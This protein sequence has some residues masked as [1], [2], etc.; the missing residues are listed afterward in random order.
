MQRPYCS[1]CKIAWS[2]Y[3]I[4]RI[5]QCSTCHSNLALASFYPMSKIIGG[6]AI[7]IISLLTIVIMQIPIIWIGGFIVGITIMVNGIKEKKSLMRLDKKA[8]PK[9]ETPPPKVNNKYLMVTCGACNTK[10][11]VKKG[12]GIVTVKC[13]ECLG[14]YRVKS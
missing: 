7:L 2:K 8:K 4:G 11:K 9:K 6:F 1:H 3:D 12:Q 10:I 13:P 14:E 5:K